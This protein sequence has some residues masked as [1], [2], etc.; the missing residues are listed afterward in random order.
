MFHFENRAKITVMLK[1][2]EKYFFDTSLLLSENFVCSYFYRFKLWRNKIV[3]KGK[4][5]IDIWDPAIEFCSYI[6]FSL[7][8]K[9]ILSHGLLKLNH[10]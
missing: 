10:V 2:T 4:P 8:I 3:P 5:Y 7:M 1:C 9:A 6:P